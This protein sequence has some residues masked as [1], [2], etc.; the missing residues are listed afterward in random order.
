MVS[1]VMLVDQRV[2]FSTHAVTVYLSATPVVEVITVVVVVVAPAVV[3]AVV[4]L[5]ATTCRISHQTWFL[6][7]RMGGIET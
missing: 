3:V 2:F 6:A 4:P 5:P 7:I 1:I